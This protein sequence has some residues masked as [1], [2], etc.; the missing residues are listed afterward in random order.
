[1]N[2]NHETEQEEMMRLIKWAF[3]G[4]PYWKVEWKDEGWS[5]LDDFHFHAAYLEQLEPDPED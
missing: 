4:H 3:E 1:M 5:N 2:E